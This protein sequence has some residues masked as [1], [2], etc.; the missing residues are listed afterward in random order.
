MVIDSGQSLEPLSSRPES[1][2]YSGEL[3]LQ[4]ELLKLR[5][6]MRMVRL[7]IELSDARAE[8]RIWTAIVAVAMIGT[9]LVTLLSVVLRR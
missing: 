1:Y 3:K 5:N 6:E 2:S 7:A 4:T 9:I 8:S